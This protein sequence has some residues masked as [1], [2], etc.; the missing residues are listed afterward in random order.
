MRKLPCAYKVI[1]AVPVLLLCSL[2]C[3][4]VL[5]LVLRE[6]SYRFRLDHSQEVTSVAFSPDG[7]FI[8][9]ASHGEQCDLFIW[10]AENGN[11]VKHFSGCSDKKEASVCGLSYSPD[12]KYLSIERCLDPIVFLLN[13]ET[14]ESIQ[15]IVSPANETYFSAFS[16]DGKFLL[17][18]DGIVRL[19]NI[20]TGREIIHFDDP[21]EGLFDADFSPNEHLIAVASGQ[22][23]LLLD[24]DNG[25]EIKRFVGHK[26]PVNDVEFSPDGE[27]LFTASSDGTVRQ[28][29]I[30]SGEEIHRF[31]IQGEWVRKA[32]YDPVTQQL[33]AIGL[34]SDIWIFDANTEKELEHLSPAPGTWLTTATI[35]EQRTYFALA[36]ERSVTIWAVED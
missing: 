9:T 30:R 17:T 33:I 10:N 34:M 36:Y 16:S 7:K 20:K 12:G 26:W 29:D 8:A 2:V 13:A 21:E 14:G 18:L 27:T 15:Q 1:I 24:A 28:W 32:F 3:C 19:W 11:R 4:F 5:F 25:K 6:R 31:D 22:V 23:A 35:N